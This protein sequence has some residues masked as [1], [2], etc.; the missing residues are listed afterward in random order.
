MK[1]T[2]AKKIISMFLALAMLFS[3]TAILTNA[4]NSAQPLFTMTDVQTRQGEEFDVTIKFARNS[5]P[6]NDPIAALDVSLKFNKDAFTVIDYYQGNGLTNAFKKLSGDK[7]LGLDGGDYIYK[8]SKSTPGEVK[9][10]LVTLKGFT[11]VSG[12]NFM[13]VRF[14]ANDKFNIEEKLD[15][16]VEVTNAAGPD[17]TDKTASYPSYTNNMDVE[18]NLT[19]LCNWSYNADTKSYTL[20]KF[21]DVNATQFTIPD[22]YE[23]PSTSYGACPVTKIN[24][25]AF[26]DS[27]KIE[28]I[29]LG[30]NITDV[31]QV[32][33]FGC[34]N[35]KRL[36]VYNKDTTFGANA[37]YGAS[38]GLVVKCYK[39]SK[40]DE[41]V[42]DDTY[43]KAHG[44]VAEYFEGIEDCTVK[45]ADEV[46]HY[47]G[48]PV[49]LPNLEVYNSRNV[50]LVQGTDYTVEYANNINIGK[51]TVTIIG[52]GEYLGQKTVEFEIYC[53]YHNSDSSFYTEKNLYADCELGGK[54]LRSCTYC[55]Y[56]D[57][58]EILPAKE[59]AEGEWKIIT[60]A[61]CGAEGLKAL[62]CPDCGKHLQEETIDKLEH[63]EFEWII[64]T[65][66]T[67]LTD[68]TESK[69]CKDCGEVVET[70]TIT[71]TGH[72]PAEAMVVV[73]AATCTESGIEGILCQNCNEVLESKEIQALGHEWNETWTV[74]KAPTCTE[75]G[76]ECILCKTCGE[77]RES[78]GVPAKGHT[79]SETWVVTTPATCTEKGTESQLCAVCSEVLN[80]RNI[81]VKGHT[82][83]EWTIIKEATCTEPGLKKIYCPDCGE[84]IR[85]K[86]IAAL[87]HAS[88]EWVLKEENK[89]TCTQPG[90][91]DHL[92]S[93]CGKV[94][95][96]KEIPAKGHT[97]GEWENVIEPTCTQPGL[98]QRVCTVCHQ[99]AQTEEIPK[100]GHKPTFVVVTLPTYKFT[101]LEKQICTVCNQ[102]LGRTR[103]IAKIVP[104]VNADTK[105]NSSDAL[106][107]LQHATGIKTLT[108]TNLKNADTNGDAKVNSTDALIILQIATG[109]IT[110]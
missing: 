50:K 7:E 83:T 105:V 84:E 63:A 78:R 91:E 22:K 71:A 20:V 62:V 26:R 67:C 12:E 35:L 4:E 48:N 89:A 1:T 79:A 56:H 6:D 107:V 43:A 18:L 30:K 25:A 2:P 8:S 97:P 31:G 101:G 106:L 68:G 75:P 51:A 96:T 95:E 60:E 24:P 45:G 69:T 39:G 29:V 87:D 74:L 88:G 47:T 40:A 32:A 99:A 23:D 11:F 38:D 73:K 49:V 21:N 59:H 72:K 58:S 108:G 80:R 102:D 104:D 15:M 34:S 81:P 61:T 53:P 44:Y 33:F 109:I 52:R 100:A 77:V 76:T 14:K 3:I 54:V 70:K 103:P 82:L 65:P 85:S 36:V 28:K 9:W 10:S 66:A 93:R 90:H 46:L 27:P 94:Y 92:C 17:F 16:T 37:L 57:E 55:G 41:Y 5:S 86:E 110:L 19:T 64:T 42:R 13:V 98:K